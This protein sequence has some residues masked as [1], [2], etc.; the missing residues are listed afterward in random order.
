MQ[1]IFTWKIGIQKENKIKEFNY[2]IF[3]NI[4]LCNK[5]LPK[6]KKRQFNV[7][8]ICNKVLSIEHLIFQCSYAQKIWFIFNCVFRIFISYKDIIC[9]IRGEKVI[10]NVS[11][12]LAFLLYKEWLLRS[13]KNEQRCSVL[14][15]PFFAHELMLR[16]NIYRNCEH[17]EI[18]DNLSMLSLAMK[19]Q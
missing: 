11:S 19:P 14:N 7:C 2:K 13:L 6:W 17:Y 1:D 12:I 16:G 8:D 18:A 3:N 10:E 15:L 9:G 4:L 5:N